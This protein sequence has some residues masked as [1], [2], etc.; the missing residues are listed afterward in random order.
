MA[1]APL[2]ALLIQPRRFPEQVAVAGFDD[3]SM[4]S[5]T[6]PALTT[7]AQPAYQMGLRQRNFFGECAGATARTGASFE[8][9]RTCACY[10]IRREVEET[11]YEQRHSRTG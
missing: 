4:S 7:I 1:L 10:K 3:I 11:G 8:D 9:S 5:L 2:E 6:R